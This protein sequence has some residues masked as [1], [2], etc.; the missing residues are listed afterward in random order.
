MSWAGWRRDELRRCESPHPQQPHEALRPG[1]QR[2]L[3]H[4]PRGTPRG[5]RLGQTVT[6][7]TLLTLTGRAQ[8]QSLWTLAVTLTAPASGTHTRHMLTQTHRRMD[9][10]SHMDPIHDSSKALVYVLHPVT[11]SGRC[12]PA[13]ALTQ[14]VRR[15]GHRALTPWSLVCTGSLPT[16]LG[17]H[18]LKGPC[19]L[20]QR[21]PT[22]GRV[23]SA[24]FC[25]V[26]TGGEMFPHPWGRRPQSQAWK[27]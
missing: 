22:L 10:Q 14:M 8:S 27:C 15:A 5:T 7:H 11:G 18:S 1:R 26:G 16:R 3:T 24:E 2:V 25:R 6:Q 21:R 20:T 17:L 19:R 23:E 4:I 9:K 13:T 12:S